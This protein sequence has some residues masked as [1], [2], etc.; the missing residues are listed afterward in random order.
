M[1]PR[2][3]RKTPL[4]KQICYGELHK[5][6]VC[7]VPPSKTLHT[8]SAT[9]LLMLVS[10]CQVYTNAA[11]TPASYAELSKTTEIITLA[12]VSS[13]CGCFPFNPAM[14]LRWAIVNHSME[15][16]R[17]VFSIDDDNDNV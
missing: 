1:N 2:I 14:G 9:H 15:F 12:S 8:Q 4:M 5:I 6:L 3:W 7:E 17:L 13:V 10:N 11:V 16:A